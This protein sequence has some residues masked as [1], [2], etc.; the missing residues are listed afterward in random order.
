M[1]ALHATA[2]DYST[3]DDATDRQFSDLDGR[4]GSAR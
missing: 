3:T 4:L 2:D 1:G